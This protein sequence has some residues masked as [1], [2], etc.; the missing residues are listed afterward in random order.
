MYSITERN[1]R[2]LSYLSLLQTNSDTTSSDDCLIDRD[3]MEVNKF[4]PNRD[5]ASDNKSKIDSVLM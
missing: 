2:I 4:P 1:I 5:L 3:P